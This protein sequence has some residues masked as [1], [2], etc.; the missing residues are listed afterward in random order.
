[1]AKLI[2]WLVLVFVV[3]LALRIVNQRNARL[4][5]RAFACADGQ[6]AKR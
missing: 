1:M 2:A 5:R 4:R 3:L 6:C